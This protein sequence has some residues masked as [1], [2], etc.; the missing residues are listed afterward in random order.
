MHL[1]LKGDK[2]TAKILQIFA[3]SYRK[4]LEVD[5]GDYTLK[6][7]LDTINDFLAVQK[8][9]LGDRFVSEI[10]VD[11]SALDCKMP[12]LLLQ[13]LVEN[14]FFHGIE[15]S[16]RLGHLAIHIHRNSNTVS[17]MVKDNGLGIPADKLQEL[18][19]KLESNDA[20]AGTGIGINNISS[21]LRL[22]YGPETNFGIESQYGIGTTIQ[23][24]IPYRK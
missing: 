4:S 21:R 12:K 22:L 8:Y 23:F 18:K 1:L 10:Q 3:A 11:E 24:E 15:L 2:E 7:E 16:N 17:I 19:A 9:R 14:A 5:S 6:D 13:P 20:A